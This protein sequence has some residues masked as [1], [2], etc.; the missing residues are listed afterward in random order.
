MKASRSVKQSTE[1]RNE[2]ELTIG[3]QNALICGYIVAKAA[4]RA[5]VGTGRGCTS[6]SRLISKRTT[7]KRRANGERGM[8]VL[9]VARTGDDL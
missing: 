4:S 6:M 3:S 2:D 5:F 9:E 8:R 1:Q 7:V